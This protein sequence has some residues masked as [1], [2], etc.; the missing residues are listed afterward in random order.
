MRRNEKEMK[1]R[2]VK[3]EEVDEELLEVARTLLSLKFGRNNSAKKHNK[4]KIN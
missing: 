1:C 2:G 3:E 4:F